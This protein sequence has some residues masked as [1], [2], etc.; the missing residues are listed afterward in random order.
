MKNI[1]FLILI[2]TCDLLFSQQNI[3]SP[4]SWTVNTLNPNQ[5]TRY[6]NL[7]STVQQS[8]IYPIEINNISLTQ[9]NGFILVNFPDNYCS[10]S[11]FRFKYSE[12]NNENDYILYG[13]TFESEDTC[14]CTNGRIT[15]HSK[16]GEKFGSMTIEDNYYTIED[17]SGSLNLIVKKNPIQN[18][19]EKCGIDSLGGQLNKDKLSSRGEGDNCEVRVLVLYTAAAKFT[20]TN[21][22]NVIQDGITATNIAFKNSKISPSQLS[23]KLAG[24]ESAESWIYEQNVSDYKFIFDY[25]KVGAGKTMFD[26]KRMQ[27]D[28]DVVIIMFDQLVTN[29]IILG[30]V[31][32]FGPSFANAIALVD[33]DN[34]SNGFTF[35]HEIGHLF[36]CRHIQCNGLVNNSCDNNGPIQH[37]HDWNFKKCFRTRVRG[38]IMSSAPNII[39]NYSNPSVKHEGKPTGLVDSRNN[40]KWLIDNACEVANFST[41]TDAPRVTISG[42]DFVC[43]LT[44]TQLMVNKSG[45]PGPYQ[46]NWFVS[47]DGINWGNVYCITSTAVIDGSDYDIGDRVYVYVIVTFG[48]GVTRKAYHT[49]DILPEGSQGYLCPR[50]KYLEDIKLYPNPSSEKLTIEYFNHSDINIKKLIEIS[51]IL[52]KNQLNFN[53][54]LQP[55]K[56]NFEIDIS[57]LKSGIY[58]LKFD[59][60]SMLSSKFL[61]Q[62]E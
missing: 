22:N 5:L 17:L 18:P 56:N 43:P 41:I 4:G 26:N 2:L 57:S 9:A 51:D 35:S 59:N 27:Y 49:L 13:E 25:L 23:I 32:D 37:G 10:N 24:I 14:E 12:Y 19:L 55:G 7:L 50:T 3:F 20:V 36:G 39:Q 11:L 8:D 42:D 53:K 45:G 40:S 62:N 16:D 28:A 61:V 44:T 58:F 15:L 29:N 34:S 46:Y 21:I 33:A 52:G 47:T 31:A 6:N 38:T 48:S 60:K 1:I 54:F 30:Q